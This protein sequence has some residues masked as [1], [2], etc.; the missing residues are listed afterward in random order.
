M[1]DSQ[2]NPQFNLG[3]DRP[4]MEGA[5]TH[6]TLFE[7]GTGPLYVVASGH[8]SNDASALRDLWAALVDR[9]ESA[10]SITFVADEYLA[11]TG[12]VLRD[13]R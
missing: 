2:F 1:S 6:V 3:W 12:K 13:N 7:G 5:A 10:A 11:L 8:G 9:N 4:F